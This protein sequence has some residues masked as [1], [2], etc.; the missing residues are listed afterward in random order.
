MIW[1]SSGMV[2][3]LECVNIV[4][5]WN[6]AMNFSF[7]K[8]CNRDL[9]FLQ[10]RWNDEIIIL[11]NGDMVKS[12]NGESFSWGNIPSMMKW[13]K[14]EMV[15]K[16]NSATNC[17]LIFNYFLGYQLCFRFLYF[18]PSFQWWPSWRLWVSSPVLSM[19]SNGLPPIISYRLSVLSDG[20]V[21]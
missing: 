15:K 11:C 18:N 4:L 14:G 5:G 21:V 9:I 7:S 1:W 2:G 3:C 19:V 12:F 6:G 8:W 20:E 10:I 17:L 16:I 13:W